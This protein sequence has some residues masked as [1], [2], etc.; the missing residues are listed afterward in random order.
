MG[1]LMGSCL[2]RKK[3]NKV[4]VFVHRTQAYSWEG[5]PHHSSTVGLST[6]QSRQPRSKTYYLPAFLLLR[7]WL[8]S[9][10]PRSAQLPETIK[11]ADK[12]TDRRKMTPK[13][14]TP[15]KM[16]L[17]R[18][19]DSKH[20]QSAAHG[21]KERRNDV[22]I[23]YPSPTALQTMSNREARRAPSIRGFGSE[24]DHQRLNTSRK[25]R[26]IRVFSSFFLYTSTTRIKERSE[27]SLQPN[28]N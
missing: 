15:N 8:P 9:S 5:N 23:L 21:F 16:R 10:I 1:P 22:F 18:N 11:A 28:G 12:E 26:F 13:V 4:N 3:W 19:G 14:N 6:R 25:K 24:Q 20:T 2:R 7:V 27:K 17:Y